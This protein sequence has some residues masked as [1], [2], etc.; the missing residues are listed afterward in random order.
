MIQ[1][2]VSD[3]FLILGVVAMSFGLAL[4]ET[5]L[6]THFLH[7]GILSLFLSAYVRTSGERGIFREERACVQLILAVWALLIGLV[8]AANASS[9]WL[10]VLIAAVM[11]V[12]VGWYW[13][14]VTVL[15]D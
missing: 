14:D 4:W 8:I 12:A 5:R 15:D 13:Y 1:I 11:S 6:T 2:K 7:G 10:A 9:P 3:L